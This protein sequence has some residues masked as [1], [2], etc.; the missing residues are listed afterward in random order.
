MTWKTIGNV[1]YKGKEDNFSPLKIPR[2]VNINS[3][4]RTKIPIWIVETGLST[5][6]F[7]DWGKSKGE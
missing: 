4:I 3:L 7:Y 6:Y 1:K 5:S 2:V